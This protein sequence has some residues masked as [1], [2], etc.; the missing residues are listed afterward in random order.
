[1]FVSLQAGRHLG[2]LYT[3]MLT[4]PDPDPQSQAKGLGLSSLRP[5]G[6]P[7]VQKQEKGQVKDPGD[8]I[9]RVMA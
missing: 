4:E 9:Q 8:G 1:M 5:R 6:L 3:E 7:G 2:E